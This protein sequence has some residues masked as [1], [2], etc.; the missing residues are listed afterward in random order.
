MHV[1]GLLIVT[2]SLVT[3]ACKGKDQGGDE[4]SAEGPA[5]SKASTKAPEPAAAEPPAK[6]ILACDQRDFISKMEKD[7]A[8]RL[9]KEPQPKRVCIDYSKRSKD[10]GAASCSQGKA[11]ETG[12]PDDGVVATCTMST[13]VVFK[14]YQGGDTSTGK[15]LCKTMEGTFAEMGK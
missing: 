2:L 4:P 12:C 10:L 15:R 13:G 1:V 5:S 6:P 8:A 11:L 14:H 3:T 7:M 9:D